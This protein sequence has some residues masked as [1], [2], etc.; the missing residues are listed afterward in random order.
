MDLG[1]NDELI[2]VFHALWDGFP[3]MARLIDRDHHILAANDTA[4]ARHFEPGGIC[5]QV[6]DPKFHRACKLNRM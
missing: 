6:N 2:E 3:G 4:I 5:A 1:N